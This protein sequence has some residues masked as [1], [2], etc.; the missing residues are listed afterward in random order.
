MKIS[1]GSKAAASSGD[2]AAVV[3]EYVWSKA[4]HAASGMG[5]A[6]HKHPPSGVNI[7]G[8]PNVVEMDFVSNIDVSV[9]HNMDWVKVTFGTKL[10]PTASAA[11]GGA[12]W[13]VSRVDVM[14]KNVDESQL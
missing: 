11:V 6:D 4:Y 1:S 10:P 3:D 12:S 7:C 14:I 2:S 9:P 13:G 5:N 8:D